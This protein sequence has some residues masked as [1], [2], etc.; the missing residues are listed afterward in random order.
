MSAHVQGRTRAF[1]LA[2]LAAATAMFG[3]LSTTG[4]AVGA[5]EDAEVVPGELV[6]GFESG[7]SRGQQRRAIS[8]A[9]A[10]IVRKLPSIDGAVVETGDTSEALQQLEGEPAVEFVEPN[11]VIRA[12]RLPN[13]DAFG[14]QWSLRN[15]GQF[16]GKPGADIDA[17][18]AWDMTT[19]GGVTVAVIDTGVDYN[20]PDLRSNIWRNPNESLNGSDDDGNGFIDDLHGADFANGD[21]NPSDDAGHGT[22]VGG[23]IGA[24]GN[25]GFGIAGVN[26][27]VNLMPLK[28]LDQNGEGNTADAASAIDYAVAHGA[29]VI[30]A[31]WGGPAFSQALY[32]AVKRAASHSVVF[33]AAAGNEGNNSDAVPDYP[34]AFDL[35]NVISVAASGRL[36]RLLSYSNYGQT[37]VDLAAPGDDIYSTVPFSSDPSGYASFS[38]T[39]MAAPAVS[40]TAALYLAHAPG[41]SAE[42]TRHAILQSVTRS[43]AYAGKTATGGRLNAAGTLGVQPSSDASPDRTA[44]SSFRLRRPRNYYVSARRRLKFKWKRSRDEGG[45]KRYKLFV[46]GRRVKTIKD[47]DGR[48]GRK[49]ATKTRVRL[50]PGK[51]T[52]YVKAFDYAGNKRR[53]RVPRRAAKSSRS[54]FVGKRYRKAAKRYRASQR[55]R[56]AAK[57][58]R[59]S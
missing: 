20:H 31:S 21:S 38:G 34:A 4:E 16:G 48:G 11:Y 32:D 25:N 5:G 26:W 49:P 52:W 12:S 41:S 35:P 56:A 47:P 10:Q 43:A 44:P 3:G 2:S 15:S 53:S 45:I 18:S 19:G 23:V 51:H 39:S 46:D 17:T 13:D 1:L 50:K 57:R 54:L 29:K 9:D 6:V 33:V 36:D 27:N 14:R 22:H 42:Q 58:R 30:N 55:R 59:A 37:S 8:G 24:E 28:F 40:G 7:S